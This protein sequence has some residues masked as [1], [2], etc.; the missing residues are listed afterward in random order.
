M[1]TYLPNVINSLRTNSRTSVSSLLQSV[2]ADKSEISSLITNLRAFQIGT[3]YDPSLVSSFSVINREFMLDA[4]RDADIRI[5]NYFNIANTVGLIINSMIDVFGSEIE[6][7]EKDISIL[8]DFINNYEYIAGKDDLFNSNYLEKFDNFLSDYRSDGV[9]FNLSD[10]DNVNFDE[11]GN[12]FV[13]T[14]SGLFKIGSSIQEKNLINQVQLLNINSNY[15]L[16]DHSDS[17][18]N[19]VF[20]DTLQ[21]SWSVSV[22]SPSV[23]RNSLSETADYCSYDTSSISGAQTFVEVVFASPQVIDTCYVT[24]NYSNGLQL[25]QIGLFVDSEEDGIIS[26][27]NETSSNFS[28]PNSSNRNFIPVLS[29][30]KI[31]D[32]VTEICFERK[33][34]NKIIM[35]FNQPIYKRTETTTNTSEIVSRKLY[36]IVKNNR[37]NRSVNIDVLQDL[38][39][40]MFTKNNTAKELLKNKSYI[41]NY[42]SYRYPIVKPNNNGS[43]YGSALFQDIKENEMIDQENSS[44]ISNMFQNFVSHVMDNRGEIFEQSTYIESASLKGSLFNFRSVGLLPLKKTDTFNM[45]RTQSSNA[46]VISRSTNSVLKDLLSQEKTDQYEYNFSLRSIS[47][48]LVQKSSSNKACFVSRK[49]NTNGHPLAVKAKLIN[50]KSNFDLTNYDYDISQSVSYELSISNKEIPDLESHWIPIVENEK[51]SIDSEV[52]FFDEQNFT[53]STRFTFKQNSLTIYKDGYTVSPLDYKVSG[54]SITLKEFDYNSIYCARYDLNKELYTYDTVNYVANGLLQES[55]KSAYSSNGPGEL[56]LSTDMT[57]RVRIENIPYVNSTYVQTASY[58]PTLGTIFSGSN[59]NYNPVKI[60]LSNGSYAINLTNYTSGSESAQFSSSSNIYFIQNGKDIIF[61]KKID[62]PFRVIYDYLPASLRF[63]LIIR[64]NIPNIEYSATAD[65]VLIK[66]KTKVYDP[67]YDKLTK[68]I[69][70]N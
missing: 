48:A 13:D 17:G 44:I 43:I 59:S 9:V 42:Y 12:G 23:I 39:Y 66:C 45:P 53:A 15:S 10:R 60:L 33:I 27:G 34:V 62:S 1:D 51:T 25:L 7:V 2:K 19:A 20:T 24:P 55:T 28:E 32:S 70:K 64:K 16:L 47:F 67:Y 5:K 37:V 29:S 11:N 68:V 14:K 57:N 46:E 18:F 58:S 26:L 56:F 3:T 31:I 61:N 49:I 38:V 41:S 30:P 54:K 22:K 4:F 63:R 6:K 52:L 35:I 36:E 50:N 69:A 21:D 40:N 65:A 8:E